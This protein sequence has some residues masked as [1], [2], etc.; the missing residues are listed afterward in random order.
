VNLAAI[1]PRPEQRSNQ[2]SGADRRQ[3]TLLRTAL[4]LPNEREWIVDPEFAA[5]Q[6]GISHI[7]CCLP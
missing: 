3:E 2:R 6:P 7:C 4:L 1:V 5:I